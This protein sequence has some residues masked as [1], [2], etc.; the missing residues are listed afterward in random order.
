M[1]VCLGVIDARTFWNFL[2][3]SVELKHRG[4]RTKTEVGSCHV[5]NQELSE[6]L[7]RIQ[8]HVLP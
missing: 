2:E 3:S 6:F 5:S 7:T 1:G 4:K 8:T